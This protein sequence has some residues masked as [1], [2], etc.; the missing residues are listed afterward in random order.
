MK[1]IIAGEIPFIDDV[2]RLCRRAAH[3]I[4]VF[5]VEDF[6]TAIEAGYGMESLAEAEIAIELHNGIGSSR[7]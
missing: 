1:V 4:Q 6:L 3:D 5:L 7:R 2:E